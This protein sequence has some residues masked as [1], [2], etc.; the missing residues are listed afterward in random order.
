MHRWASLV[1]QSPLTRSTAEQTSSFINPPLKQQSPRNT[2][3]SHNPSFFSS[4]LFLKCDTLIHSY[5]VLI[6]VPLSRIIYFYNPTF[7]FIVRIDRFCNLAFG[8]PEMTDELRIHMLVSVKRTEFSEC[9]WMQQQGSSRM[10]LCPAELVFIVE[11]LSRQLQT[12]SFCFFYTNRLLDSTTLIALRHEPGVIKTYH[13][14]RFL[15]TI[16][17][18]SDL[19]RGSYTWPVLIGIKQRLSFGST[20]GRSYTLPV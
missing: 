19:L 9:G 7:L 5:S 4:D 8:S 18:D 11:T 6:S 15:L 16:S 2:F 1:L 17:H 10:T 12:R 14:I 13:L 3:L 20:I